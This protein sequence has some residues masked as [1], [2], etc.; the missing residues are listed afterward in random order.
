MAEFAGFLSYARLDDQYED[1]RVTEFRSRLENAVRQWTGERGFQIFQDTED[2]RW[3]QKWEGRIEEALEDVLI[4]IPIMTPLY[5][6]SEASRWEYELFLKREEKLGRKDLI[7][8]VYWLNCDIL[9]DRRRRDADPW[10]KGLSNHQRVDWSKFRATS[11]DTPEMRQAFDGLALAIKQTFEVTAGVTSTD[12]AELVPDALEEVGREAPQTTYEE[13]EATPTAGVQVE[14]SSQRRGDAGYMGTEPPTYTFDAMG[15]GD[16][17]SLV[18]AVKG[19]NPGDRLLVRPGFYPGGLVLD[20]PMEIIG[21]G[22]ASEIVVQATGSDVIRFETNMGIVRSLSIRQVGGG[23]W[24]AVDLT[25]GRLVIEDC[26]IISQSL[27]AVGVHDGADPLVRRD[28]IHDGKQSGI[29]VYD[30]G[31]GTFE[32]NEV[33]GNA[34][35]GMAVGNGGDPVVRRNHIHGNS[36]TA[37]LVFG[38]SAGTFEDNDLRGNKG[39]SW[40]IDA[41]CSLKVARNREDQAD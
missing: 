5:F 9:E 29:Y 32:E 39:G 27:A 25:Q 14:G 21:V 16:Y 30:N 1:G 22:D 6:S 37:V 17:I 35:V 31:R 38:K 28:R 40:R 3:G 7:L 4:L 19:S 12:D 8:P 15:R 2:I 13:L 41:G 18:E 34:H 23:D 33:W 36:L 24:I 11:F 20:K 26:D 10:A